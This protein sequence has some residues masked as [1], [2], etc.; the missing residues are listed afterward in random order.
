MPFRR[1]ADGKYVSPSGTVYTAKQVRA[2]YATDGFTRD[3]K[4]PRQRPR[5]RQPSARRT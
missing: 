3:P 5:R 1:R 2:Y 4:H